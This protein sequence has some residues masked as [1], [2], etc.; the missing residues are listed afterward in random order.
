MSHLGRSA[1]VETKAWAKPPQETASEGG[2]FSEVP[3]L[4]E[5]SATFSA[6]CFPQRERS[7]PQGHASLRNE[8]RMLLH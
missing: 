5:A 7:D 8:I 4:R 2:I 1:S 6:N 3:P